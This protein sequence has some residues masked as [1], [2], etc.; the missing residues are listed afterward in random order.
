MFFGHIK[1][2]KNL[3]F[4]FDRFDARKKYGF[5]VKKNTKITPVKQKYEHILTGIRRI[6]YLMFFYAFHG[7]ALNSMRIT[8]TAGTI[9][10][11][12]VGM[13]DTHLNGR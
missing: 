6:E 1:C 8:K 2:N 7:E 13:H 10:A 9:P 3:L 4:R 12:T 11:T 5:I